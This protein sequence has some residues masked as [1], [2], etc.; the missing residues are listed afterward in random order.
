METDEP[1]DG[2]C[3]VSAY[4]EVWGQRGPQLVDLGAGHAT[5]GRGAENDVALSWDSTVSQ[6]HAVLERYPA[7]WSVRDLGS[8]NGTFVN[9]TRVAAEHRLRNGDEVTIGSSR[10][11]FRVRN[12]PASTLTAGA[13]PPP[14]ITRREREVC[15]RCARR[16][17][18]GTCSPRRP[19]SRTSPA[20][21]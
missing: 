1:L 11:V 19:P 3:R 14:D 21:S 20:S 15:S 9:N 8:T 12:A 2:W 4:L 6:L 10:L 16:W 18:T 7:G 5:I 17:S 13:Q